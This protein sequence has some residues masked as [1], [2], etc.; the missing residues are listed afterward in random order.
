VENESV[1]DLVSY[2]A[3]AEIPPAN[4]TI[5]AKWLYVVLSWLFD[6]QGTAL[7]LVNLRA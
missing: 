3:K 6:T 1:A 7:N 2:L 5:K 4:E